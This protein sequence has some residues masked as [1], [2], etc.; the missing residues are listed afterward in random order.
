MLNPNDELFNCCWGVT[1]GHEDNANFG[2]IYVDN[3]E[4]RVSNAL[5][6]SVLEKEGYIQK[7]SQPDRKRGNVEPS[8]YFSRGSKIRCQASKKW[9]RYQISFR[10]DDASFDGIWWGVTCAGRNTT[11]SD[12]NGTIRVDA[13][14]PVTTKDVAKR[15]GVTPY[16]RPLGGQE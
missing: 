10:K 11:S 4:I 2:Y 16:D 9:C 1:K 7:A 8:Y 12:S 3:D 6:A 5:L 13:Y 14:D 15:V